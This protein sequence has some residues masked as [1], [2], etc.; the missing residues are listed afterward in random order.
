M[1]RWRIKGEDLNL[2]SSLG[3]RISTYFYRRPTIALILLL[4]PPLLWLGVVYL[5]ALFA[6]LIESF[7]HL[8]GFTGQVVREF[9]LSTY[10]E[11]FTPAHLDII[12]RTTLMAAAVTV[13]SI[14]LAFPVAYYMA[15]YASSKVKAAMYLAVLLPLWSSY[16]VRIYAWKLILAKEGV[17]NWFITQLQLSGLLDA[18][19]GLP[20]IGGPSLSLS[21]L[22][23][24]IVFVHIWLPY[25]ILP[26]QAALERVPPSLIEASSDLG[27]RPSQTFHHVILPL[28]IP[29][30]VAGS[31]FT[32]SL[33]LG[34]FIIPQTFGNS[35]FFIGLAVLTNQGVAGN[36]PLAAAFTVVP[37][38]IMAF[39]LTAAKKVGA[40]D[41]L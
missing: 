19:L 36:I 5:G 11:L 32:F 10:G 23:M 27:A 22:G 24:F 15:R 17:F 18:V 4:T 13:V 29:G 25:M 2:P 8:D 34:D 7:F 6:L 31:I 14:F 12:L 1:D 39:Y 16:L 33:T 9:T 35:S 41:A 38:V 30:V 40:F 28:A 3:R 21:S 37:M 26:I 20:V